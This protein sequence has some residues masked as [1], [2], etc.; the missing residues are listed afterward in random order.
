MGYIAAKG[1][2]NFVDGAYIESFAFSLGNGGG[3]FSFVIDRKSAYC[4]YETNA[5]FREQLENGRYVYADG[6]MVLND[7][8]YVHQ[9]ASGLRLTPWANAHVDACCLRFINIYEPYGVAD[10]RFGTMNS[11]EEYN[12]H[13]F[14]FA[15]NDNTLSDREK[16][17]A[18]SHTLD[19]LPNSF[20]DA[21]TSL[22]KQAHMTIEELEERALLSR[23]TI[24]RLRTEERRDYSLDQVIAICIAL[25]LPPWLSRA[26]IERAGFILRPTKQHLAY[27][28]ALDCLFMDSVDD[29][30]KFLAEAGC[31]QLRLSTTHS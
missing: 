11:D 12:R 15:H 3:D 27:Q 26:M 13:Y 4:I 1:A 9:T 22:M 7:S 31:Q 29:V 17:L 25:H 5:S 21:L 18:M 2:L 10:Y 19:A 28:F 6:H 16:L 30:Q 8:R 23:R 24:S 14:T 20:Q